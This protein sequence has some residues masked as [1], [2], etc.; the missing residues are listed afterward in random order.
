M[1]LGVLG[2]IAMVLIPIKAHRA[3]LQDQLTLVA[4]VIAVAVVF[5]GEVQTALIQTSV[6]YACSN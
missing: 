3:R 1:T 6:L 5:I 4:K 2:P